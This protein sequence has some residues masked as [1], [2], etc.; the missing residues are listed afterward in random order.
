[1]SKRPR[2]GEFPRHAQENRSIW[3]ANAEW[4][5]DHIGDG[6]DFQVLLIEPATE[7]VLRPQKGDLILD[8][9]CGA[10]RFARRMAELGARV[11]ALDHS[12]RFIRRARRRTRSAAVEYRVLDAAD[13]KAFLSL[14][15][16]RFDKAVC[17]MALMDMPV[18]EP[19]M[20]ALREVLKPGAAFVFSVI[21]PC[22]H[23]AGVQRFCEMYE[24]EAGRHI[25]RTGVKVSAYVTPFAKK[26][27]GIIGQPKPQY[28]FHRPIHVLFG[29]A[30]KA[31]FVADAI[32]EPAYPPPEKRKAGVRWDDMP[33]IPPVMV[34]RMR[35]S[36]PLHEP[37]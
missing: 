28:Y 26:T 6:N 1:M 16:R 33:E 19:L 12:A 14:G 4:W 34:V 9:A 17:T 29:A 21:H 10:G 25:I 35:L 32:E 24:E 8:I 27:E 37:V 13:R 30:F 15:K 20:S 5:D 22:F 3:D 23:S 31:G 36:A 2:R 7:R 18:V 11:V